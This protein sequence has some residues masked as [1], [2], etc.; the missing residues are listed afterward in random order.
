MCRPMLASF[1]DHFP[2]RPVFPATLLLDSAIRV[3]GELVASSPNGSER[4]FRPTRMTHVKMRD[5][6][7]PGQSVAL[8]AQTLATSDEIARVGLTARVGERTVATARVEF[9][10]EPK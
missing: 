4:C 3:A 6:V 2:R 1:R 9:E 10:G 8:T 5:W 7:L